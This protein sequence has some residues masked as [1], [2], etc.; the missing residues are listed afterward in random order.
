MKVVK[1]LDNNLEEMLMVL[2]LFGIAI[3]M[4]VQVIA[5]YAINYSLSWSDELVRYFLVWSCF[6]SVSFCVKKRISIKIDSV[7]HAFP[8]KIKPWIRAARHLLIL[9]FC[10]IM[11]PYAVT[12]V[13]QAIASGATS[14]AMEI[15]MYFMQSAPLVGFVLLAIRCCQALIREVRLGVKGPQLAADGTVIETADDGFV[16]DILEV[17]VEEEEVQ[18]AVQEVKEELESVHAKSEEKKGEGEE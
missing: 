18:A 1:W 7:L 11:I 10:L 16:R 17:N 14:A 12:F 2:L 5:R 3:V 4:I 13:R 15:P 8:E 6:L 9:V